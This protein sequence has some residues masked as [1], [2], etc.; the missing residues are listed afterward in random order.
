M[1]A[2]LAKG[3]H[4]LVNP[5][6]ALLVV[7]LAVSLLWAQTTAAQVNPFGDSLDLKESDIA[8]LQAAASA[9]FQDDKA[10]IGET[11]NWSNPKTDDSGAVSLRKLFK[12]ACTSCKR[13]Q[14]SIKQK[15]RSDQITYQF[16]RC[17]ADDGS[18]KL[19]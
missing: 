7:V 8:V 17:R 3:G 9:L 19:L 2:S 16:A 5:L 6:R 4:Q 18:W 12:H 14:H 15:G 11:K 1:I 10:G 13:L